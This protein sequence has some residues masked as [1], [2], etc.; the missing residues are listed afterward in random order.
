MNDNKNHKSAINSNIK[1]SPI[2]TKKTINSPYLNQTNEPV[3]P[4][5]YSAKNFRPSTPQTK[6]L[7]PSLNKNKK[8][9]KNLQGQELV[10]ENYGKRQNFQVD[11]LKKIRQ[12][13]D[14]NDIKNYT[15]QTNITTNNPYSSNNV[16]SSIHNKSNISNINSN[17]NQGKIS[18]INKNTEI[19]STRNKKNPISLNPYRKKYSKN[20]AAIVIQRNFRDYFK[21]KN[22]INF[23]YF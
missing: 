8:S 20:D 12:N 15:N 19:M 22:F 21:V 2:I 13:Y 23:N 5:I 6:K 1:A 14:N 10:I 18:N 17:F 9:S 7:N 11:N 16:N 4:Q 3:N